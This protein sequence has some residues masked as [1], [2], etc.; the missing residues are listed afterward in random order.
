MSNVSIEH[1]RHLHNLKEKAIAARDKYKGKVTAV[2]KK[3]ITVAEVGAGAW[4]GGVIEGKTNGAT[5]MH[6][7]ANLLAGALAV[8]AS[9]LDLAGEHSADLG[10]FGAGLVASF[11]ASHGHLFGQTWQAAGLS[12]ALHGGAPALPAAPAVHGVP[13]PRAM[14]GVVSNMG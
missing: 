5:I 1:V 14:A 11:A 4:A 8:G 3:A 13:D 7:P 10:N 9:M 12:A 6:V 2:A